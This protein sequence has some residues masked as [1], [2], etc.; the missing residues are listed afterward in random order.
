MCHTYLSIYLPIFRTPWSIYI[1]QNKNHTDISI[2]NTIIQSYGHMNKICLQ[3]T[4]LS[5]LLKVW[6]G[7]CFYLQF[8]MIFKTISLFFFSI[9]IILGLSGPLVRYLD[10]YTVTGSG[11]VYILYTC[12]LNCTAETD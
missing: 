6:C 3:K 4:V 12:I 1:Q 9:V 2:N 7:F 11:L 8:G 10:M 5:L